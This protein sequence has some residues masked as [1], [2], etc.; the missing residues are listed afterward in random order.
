MTENTPQ[1][2]AQEPK[3]NDKEFNFRNLEQKYKAQLEQERAA[4][5]E[6]E[7]IAEETRKKYMAAQDD[8]EDDDPYVNKKKL[9]KEQMKFGE[10]IKQETQ[11]EINKAVQQALYEERNQNWLRNN[12]DF[13]DVMKNAQKLY[14]TDK[15][16]AETILE[17][18][19]S[20]ERQKLVYKNI[21]ALGLHKDQ[22]K[23]P[24]IQ[25]KIDANRKSPYY[26]PTGVGTAPY[27]SQSDFSVSGQ[28]NAYD[29][30][31]E[32]QKRLRI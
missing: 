25:D 5:L 7:R 28:K 2:Q 26:Q 19:D 31:K 23:Q 4:R 12:P 13:V 10:K 3:T 22:P 29:K 24:S 30:M 11:S 17:M 16:L 14:E 20:F 9:Q 6:A 8:D 21:K 32:L 1:S 15:E 18:P 27:N